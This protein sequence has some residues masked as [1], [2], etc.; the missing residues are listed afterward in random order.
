MISLIDRNP[1]FPNVTTNRMGRKWANLFL[2]KQHQRAA[3]LGSGFRIGSLAGKSFQRDK[4]IP[5]IPRQFYTSMH[6]QRYHD[7]GKEPTEQPTQ[8][9]GPKIVEVPTPAILSVFETAVLSSSPS[10][11]W[12]PPP[13]QNA[14]GIPQLSQQW[15]RW[16]TPPTQS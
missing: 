14:R 7:F 5:R 15:N 2:F 8:A 3:S 6:Q 16:E 1:H 4:L 11:Q 10:F 12:R 9:I 13:H